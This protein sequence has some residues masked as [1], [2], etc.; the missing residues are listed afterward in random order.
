MKVLNRSGV[1]VPVRYDE[2]TDRI[3]G[4]IQ[5][6]P[7][8]DG[9]L[10]AAKVA[11]N[12]IS[13]IVDGIKTSE[14]DRIAAI[15]CMNLLWEHPDYNKLAGRLIASDLQKKSF[16]YNL[17]DLYEALHEEGQV[18]EEFIG[19]VREHAATLTSFIQFERDFLFDYFGMSTLV[20]G[21]YLKRSV[22]R[23]DMCET[24]QHLFLRVALALHKSDLDA[25]RESYEAFSQKLCTHATPTLFH[26]GSE[27]N[28]LASCFLL[29]I[30]DSID[31]MYSVAHKCAKIS[32]Y[33]GGIG[34]AVTKIRAKGS[35][36]N[37]SKGRST[38]MLPYLQVLDA[39]ARHV[40]QGGK[41][42]GSIAVYIEP[43]HADI[44]SVIKAKHPLTLPEERAN[45]LFYAL[46]TN[47]VFMERVASQGT[48]SLFCPGEHPELVE[49]VG[50]AFK[51]RYVE[52][53]AE[54][55]FRSQMPAAELW[56]LILKSQIETGM[57]YLLFKDACNLKSNQRNLGTIY[58]SNLCA[59]IVEK[60]SNE[61]TAVC[62][63]A[64]VCL[65]SFVQ[66]DSRG[67]ELNLT[68]LDKTV[69]M[70]VRNLNKAIDDMYYTT[71]CARRS[72][73][74][75]RPIGIGVQGYAD[76]FAMMGIAWESQE[77]K[78]VT[79]EISSCM[80]Y[81]AIAESCELARI[82]GETSLVPGSLS[83]PGTTYEGYVGSPIS[84]G[85]FQFDLW[86]ITS[87][88]GKWENLRLKVMAYGVRNSLCIAL[89]PT[90][91]TSNIMGFNESFEPFTFNL[92][93]RRT[94][95]GEFPLVN[96]Y[97]VTE[98]IRLGLWNRA[99][100]ERVVLAGG[101]I[102]AIPEIPAELKVLFKTARELKK[103]PLLE[104]AA[105]RGRYVCQTQSM[106]LYIDGKPSD[107]QLLHNCH[108]KSWKL[109]LKTASYYTHS[110]P[111]ARPQNFT[112]DPRTERRIAAAAAVES[113]EPTCENCS[114]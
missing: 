53:E 28:Q 17:C 82:A 67:S 91:S 5:V 100:Y 8:L 72:N 95:A 89:M 4:L 35:L 21:S 79:E 96:K 92:Y 110:M 12:V 75:R 37:T 61:E 113:E 52:L 18:S 71:D 11:H 69:R 3:Q 48:W 101:S 31:D 105:I 114:A 32:K 63:L 103:V 2:I 46:W 80:Y 16:T 1:L 44:V 58:S 47:D 84:Q 10:D 41:R 73:L 24:P 9:S 99:M 6:E 87:D 38:G 54:G 33:G 74:G 51:Q 29:Q 30:D 50:P 68:K 62:N 13:K 81:A 102:Q 86:G 20:N 107:V 26:A 104:L 39:L 14:L 106:N 90:A 78:A 93:S 59:E 45:N 42:A 55:S 108:M 83:D 65:P 64:S 97:L 56:Q 85:N 15:E 23:P 34:V 88:L 40:D 22:E 94:L 109:G 112:I 60:T 98:L 76:V 19:L 36:I 7:T 27:R 111:A 49:L 57:P 66:K 25:V 77:A 70:L 43:W